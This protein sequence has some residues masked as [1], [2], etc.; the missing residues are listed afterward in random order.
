P[1]APPPLPQAM[2]Q[3]RPPARYDPP[4]H[5]L[6]A[7]IPAMGEAKPGH[8]IL[9]RIARRMGYMVPERHAAQLMTDIARLV[10]GYGGISYARLERGGI[11]V[12]SGHYADG[13][14]P[15]LA[16][17]APGMAGLAPSHTGSRR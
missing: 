13:G 8:E 1:A 9:G 10:P 17:G 5:R 11:T 2:D 14:T 16:P 7:A 12:P 15:I 6:R 3:H 4:D